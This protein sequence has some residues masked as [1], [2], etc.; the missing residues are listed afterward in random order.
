MLKT[1]RLFWYAE[2]M[3]NTMDTSDSKRKS[4]TSASVGNSS[5]DS[6]VDALTQSKMAALLRYPSNYRGCVLMN[7]LKVGKF[8]ILYLRFE[9]FWVSPSIL[10]T[11]TGIFASLNFCT[12]AV[13]SGANC[14]H[15]EHH[16]A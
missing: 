1:F 6:A 14:M 13:Y 9:N 3:K 8:L 12:N 5:S 7:N 11:T 4:S 10:A 16:L 15:G 2:S